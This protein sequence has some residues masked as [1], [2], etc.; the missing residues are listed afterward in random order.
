MQ[1]AAAQ[2]QARTTSD[3]LTVS[4]SQIQRLEKKSRIAKANYESLQIT[5]C[6]IIGNE[7]DPARR[8]KEDQHLV[9]LRKQI[10]QYDAQI[11]EIKLAL[12]DSV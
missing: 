12:K 7:D 10:K 5:L 8:K 6:T 4:A 3:G 2:R 11:L 9:E 1:A